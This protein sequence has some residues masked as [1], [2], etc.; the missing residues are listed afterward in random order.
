MIKNGKRV[1]SSSAYLKPSMHR[2]NLHVVTR[3]KVNRIAFNFD[4]DKK[5]AVGVEFEFATSRHR[6]LTN[7]EVILSAGTIGS[8]QLLMLSGVGPRQYLESNNI[9]VV[10]DSPQV[11]KN[12]KD[13]IGIVL[14]YSIDIHHAGIETSGIFSFSGLV[15]TAFEYLVHKTGY[16]AYPPVEYIG[17]LNSK[18]LL[19][20]DEIG[21]VAPEFNQEIPDIQFYFSPVDLYALDFLN[22]TNMRQTVHVKSKDNIC[23]LESVENKNTDDLLNCLVKN[24]PQSAYHPT[25]SCKMGSK[26]ENG[27]VDEQFRVHGVQGLRIVDASVFPD[28]VSAN[29]CATVYALAEK[30][31]DVM[32]NSFK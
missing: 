29:P 2:P 30:A 5:K 25:S 31:A 21:N 28:A 8:A 9:H 15:K 24:R 3:A 10:Q 18:R 19:R 27:V 32:L 11:G 4:D 7:R 1:S 17:F 16:L 6:V 14:R 13:H 12:L 26:I 20:K 22:L 23:T